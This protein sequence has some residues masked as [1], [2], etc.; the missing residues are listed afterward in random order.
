MALANTYTATVEGVVA[1][2]VTVEANVGPGLPGMYMV[3]LGDATVRESR[4]RIK[5]AVANSR[6]PWPKTKIMVSLSPANLPKTGSHFDLAI[7]LAVLNTMAPHAGRKLGRT[8]VAGELGLDGTLRAIDGVLPMLATAR[9]SGCDTVVIP[10]ANAHEAAL[11]G[12][13]S[14]LIAETLHDVWSWALGEAKLEPATDRGVAEHHQPQL[15]DFAD[16]A[17]Q[18]E[19]KHA[20]EVAAAGGHHVFMIGPPG[21]GKSM[22]AQRIPSILPPLTTQQQVEVTAVQSVSGR[23]GQSVATH[24]PFVAP[25]PSVTRA[26]LIGGGS[27]IARPGAVSLAHRGVLFLD[28]ASEIPAATLDALRVPMEE[29]RVRLSRTRR[30]VEFPAEFQLVLAA[31]P[32]RCGAEDARACRCTS[33]DRVTHLNNVSGPLRDRIDLFVRTTSTGAVLSSDNAEPSVT[34]AERVAAA[35]ER[36]RHRWEAAGVAA[37]VNTN[38][39]AALLRRRFPA[40]DSAMAL[41]GAYLATGELSQRGVDRTLKLAWTLCDLDAAAVPDIDH[42]ARAT[43]LRGGALSEVMS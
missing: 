8:L 39:P 40:E 27:G 13:R 21:S 5:T 41:L 20:M 7:A 43:Q 1:H 37:S 36:A 17:G 35:R 26:A 9:D 15:P 18:D 10:A 25:H 31:N 6:L 34:I 14:I 30:D 11:L 4:D 28:E 22:I 38:V 3:G 12:D 23:A 42:V 29:G 16:I 32:C 33:R 2:P 24:A 19:A